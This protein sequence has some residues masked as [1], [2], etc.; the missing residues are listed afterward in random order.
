MDKEHVYGGLQRR[1]R[2]RRM[3]EF[4]RRFGITGRTRVLDVGGDLWNWQFLP[5]RPRLTIVNVF[6]PRTP[7][8]PDVD[9][10]VGDGT[11]LPFADRAF[12][13]VYSNSVVEHLGTRE[14]QR[15]FAA[16][17]RRTGRAYYVQTPN[18]WF[19]FEPHLIMPFIHFLPRAWQ[20]PLY[21]NFTLWGLIARPT[22]EECDLQFAQLHLLRYR[23]FRDL[24]PDA[25]ILR[26]RALGMTKSFMAIHAPA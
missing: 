5:V 11:R 18:F 25:T 23:D 16:E 19:P 6:P 4:Q 1:F 15:R 13:V 22:E 24:F 20:R 8:P 21:R 12:D 2:A 3:R 17:V 9:W 10:V 26:E 14:N 7:L